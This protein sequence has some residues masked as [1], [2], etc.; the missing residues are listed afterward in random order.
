MNVHDFNFPIVNF[1]F[2][3]SNIPAAPAYGICISQLNRYSRACCSYQEFLDRGLLL[4]RKLLYQVFLLVKL[5][6]SLRKFYGCHHDLV[7]HYGT[8]V[9]QMS[10]D[11]FHFL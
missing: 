5:K 8:S 4:T 3:C 11:M 2:I 7:N 10:M 9:S 1:P 6:S